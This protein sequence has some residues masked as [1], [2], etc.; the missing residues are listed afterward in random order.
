MMCETED[1]ENRVP[2]TLDNLSSPNS[3][4]PLTPNHLLTIK[5]RVVLLGVKHLE[6]FNMLIST[7][8]K[9]GAECNIFQMKFGDSLAQRI[10]AVFTRAPEVGSSTL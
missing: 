8:E 10:R 6:C 7:R 3:S 5:W 1:K 9:D 2:F 4:E